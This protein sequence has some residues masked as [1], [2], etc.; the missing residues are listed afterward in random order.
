[1]TI[2]DVIKLLPL[3]VPSFRLEFGTV[4]DTRPSSG[5][6]AK[7]P[8]QV[9]HSNDIIAMLSPD[10]ERVALGKGL[11]ARGNVEN[12]LGMVE[13][14]M[15]VTLRR[16]L[17]ASIQDFEVSDKNDWVVRLVEH[18]CEFKFFLVF[19]CYDIRSSDW[20]NSMKWKKLKII[21]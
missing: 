10:G 14:N 17:K 6:R 1:M 8:S 7:T 5:D 19:Y 13:E 12:W 18:Y 2:T 9:Q 16:L 11:K 21:F 4:Q 15:M 20:A 3:T